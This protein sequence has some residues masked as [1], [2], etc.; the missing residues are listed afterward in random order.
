MKGSCFWILLILF[1]GCNAFVDSGSRSTR[2]T[3]LFSGEPTPT[4]TPD[5]SLPDGQIFVESG[6]C[7][8]KD[9][10]PDSIGNCA[11]KCSSRNI[12]QSTLFVDVFFGPEIEL[13]Q[14]LENLNGFCSF[15]ADQADAGGSTTNSTCLLEIDDGTN[16]VTTDN[17][18]IYN[19]GR[20]FQVPLPDNLAAYDQTYVMRLINSS[21]EVGS[22]YFQVRKKEYEEPGPDLGFLKI[23][24]AHMYACLFTLPGPGTTLQNLEFV[25]T[26]RRFYLYPEFITPPSIPPVSV[27]QDDDGNLQLSTQFLIFCHNP[28]YNNQGLFDSPL[29]PRHNLK[30]NHLYFWD[31]SDVRFFDINPANE[32]LDI[33]ERITED[34]NNLGFDTEGLI[35][36]FSEINWPTYPC[37]EG[38]C[39]ND[40]PE[41]FPGLGFF[42]KV[43]VNSSTGEVFCPERDDYENGNT[44]FQVI[45]EYVGV[46]TEGIYLG[47]KEIEIYTDANGNV[48]TSD[49][50]GY[51]FVRQS[52]LENIWFYVDGDQNKIP[53]TLESAKSHTMFYYWPI[54]ETNGCNP[55]VKQANQKLYTIR[56][57]DSVYS[58]GD[59]TK[60][61]FRQ[62][63][64]AADKRFGCI[65]KG[66]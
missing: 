33:N 58:E 52:V 46:D 55:L 20:G 49:I 61:G 30:E 35:E 16:K 23:A 57:E 8:C 9:A 27:T 19:N 18:T 43:W 59:R 42:M 3:P 53:G 5:T 44:I 28:Q 63:F 50:E 36:V 56:A 38:L 65:P 24:P 1:T 66:T 15:N 54:C 64:P 41:N 51:M 39:Q 60:I 12:P 62:S 6:F 17:V 37:E 25:D 26:S 4:P 47:E 22:T 31:P 45:G 14:V 11:E 29:Y 13:N 2:S 10:K 21:Q 7:V 34:V 40:P 48:Q 32:V